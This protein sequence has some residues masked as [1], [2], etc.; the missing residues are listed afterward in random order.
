[1]KFAA[2]VLPRMFLFVLSLFAF[3]VASTPLAH[4][5]CGGV[6]GASPAAY[7]PAASGAGLRMVAQ[8]DEEEPI[9]GL[10]QIKVT[11]KGNADVP[12]GVVLDQG[13]AV[14]HSDHTEIINSGRTP[15]SQSFCL[16]TWKKVG[17]LTYKLNHFALSWTKDA[18]GEWVLQGPSNIKQEVVVDAKHETYTGT[19]TLDDYDTKGKLLAHH[20]ATIIGKRLGIDSPVTPM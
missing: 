15:A 10:W 3:S 8:A 14:W 20:S 4:A 6:P 16:G 11:A 19:F 1:M 17:P 12:D 9:V 7:F 13:Y 18:K 5:G 2:H